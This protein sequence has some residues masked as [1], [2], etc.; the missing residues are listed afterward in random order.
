MKLPLICILAGLSAGPTLHAQLF[1]SGHIDL[2]IAYEGGFDLHLHDEETDT[3]YAPSELTLV[4]GLAG[5]TSTPAVLSAF[6]TVG[7]D[8]WILPKTENENLP[9][10]GIGTEELSIAD[11]SGNLTLTLKSVT[12]PGDFGLYDVGTFGE[13]L[14]LM[15]SRDGITG[16]D[17]L[18]V[19]PG[20]HAHYNFTFNAPGSYLVGFE[21]TG[22]HTVD[23]AVSSG[24]VEYQFTVVPEPEEY[25]ALAGAG[26]IGFALWRRSRRQA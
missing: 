26:L 13:I 6:A 18:T 16:G 19:A 5:K 20:T 14:P 3:E 2:G 22:L 1:T 11:W 4:V 21:A 10:L 12:G 7:S 8:I 23:G 17:A 25:A 24:T 9:F 15:N